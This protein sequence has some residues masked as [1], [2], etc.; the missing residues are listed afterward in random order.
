MLCPNKTD[1]ELFD[2][3]DCDDHD[4]YPNE[5]ETLAR[6]AVALKQVEEFERGETTLRATRHGRPLKPEPDSCQ[7]QANTVGGLRRT[8]KNK[9]KA[10]T[11]TI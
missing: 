5:E 11:S 6:V 1:F 9:T 2:D 3:D 4:E 10:A 8:R 7:A